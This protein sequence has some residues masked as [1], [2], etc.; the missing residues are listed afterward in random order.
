MLMQY[1]RKQQDTAGKKI[2][3]NNQVSKDIT[4]A[5]RIT[6]MTYN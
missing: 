4:Q 3:E 1:N 5:K 6:R 2:S